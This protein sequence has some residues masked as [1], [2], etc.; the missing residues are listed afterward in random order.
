MILS[1]LKSNIYLIAMKSA[2][3]FCE[4]IQTFEL[5]AG[6][7]DTSCNT[8]LVMGKEYNFER[9]KLVRKQELIAC[10]EEKLNVL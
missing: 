8:L 10:R 1:I 9:A 7:Y 4:I 3:I 6:L 5:V 2:H